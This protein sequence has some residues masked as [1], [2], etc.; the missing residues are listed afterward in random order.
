MLLNKKNSISY[1]K[2]NIEV[3]LCVNNKTIISTRRKS[4]AIKQ[5]IY[6]KYKENCVSCAQEILNLK[7]VNLIEHFAY[8]QRCL[9]PKLKSDKIKAIYNH[10]LSQYKW[11]FNKCIGLIKL[12]TL[13]L[14]KDIHHKH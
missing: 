8:N 14:A 2:Y 3:D 7:N 1:T 10:L 4:V 9:F 12:P 6:A 11:C 5:G 13:E